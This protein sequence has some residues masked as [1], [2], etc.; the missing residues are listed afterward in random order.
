MSGIKK[1]ISIARYISVRF[2][3]ITLATAILM[4]VFITYFSDIAIENDLRNQVR[5]ESRYDYLNIKRRDGKL[6]VNR[7]FVYEDNG[8]VKVVLDEDGE[9]IAGEYPDD[10]ME[11]VAVSPK[12]VREIRSGDVVYYIYDRSI[13]KSDETGTTRVI[14]YVRSVAN[15]GDL[16]SGYRYLKYASYVCA[17]VI[18]ILSAVA[19]SVFSRHIVEPIRDICEDSEKIGREKDLSRR[20]EYD[21]MFQEMDI[22]IQANNRMM[23]RLE[24]MFE[25]QKQFSSDVTHELRT[26]VS[27]MMAQCQYARKHMHDQAEFEEAIDLLERQV[28]KTSAIIS[29][30][31]QLSRLDQEKISTDFEYVDLRDIVEE[32]CE[33]EKLRDS[34]NMHLHLKLEQAEASVDVGLIMSAIRNLVNNAIKYSEDNADIDIALTKENGQVK[35]MVRDYGRGMDEN[36]KR[37][38]FDRFYRADEARN[39]EGFGLGLSIAARIIEIHSGTITVESR[40]G[41]GS[42]FYVTIPVK[43]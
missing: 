22:L 1:K 38:I 14:A 27:V 3:G 31:L 13:V 10:A 17:G 23:D 20:M 6:K 42:T 8:I 11:N 7:N 16:S 35:F 12:I 36:T 5:R 24:E 21:G 25:R 15:K 34:R 9:R 37:H 26:P 2:I 33:N 30:I 43:S 32:V 18:V 29:Q 40:E 19:S 41:E 28:R 4:A 39:S